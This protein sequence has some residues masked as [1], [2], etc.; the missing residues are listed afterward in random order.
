MR[1]E[2]DSAILDRC[3]KPEQLKSYTEIS[4]KITSWRFE[5][6]HYEPPPFIWLCWRCEHLASS[7]PQ[8]CGGWIPPID[9]RRTFAALGLIKIDCRRTFAALFSY[10]AIVDKK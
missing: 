2:A 3:K 1:L 7:A 10:N 5:I 9:C 8:L 6:R 4:V